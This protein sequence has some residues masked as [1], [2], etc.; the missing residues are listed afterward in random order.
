VRLG[1][2]DGMPTECALSL[3]NVAVVP[4]GFFVERVT[5]L[6]TDRLA[7]VCAALAVASGCA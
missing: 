7:E 3:D 1:V 5:K 4:R 2:E 6:R